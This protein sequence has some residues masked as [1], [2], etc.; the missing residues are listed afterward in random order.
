M[1]GSVARSTERVVEVL[2]GFFI[3]DQV[4]KRDGFLQSRDPRVTVLAIAGFALAVVIARSFLVLVGLALLTGFIAWRSAVPFKAL[5]A[6]SA[7]VPLFSAMIVLPQAVLLAGDPIAGV[8]GVTVTNTG[9][10][11]V[12][13]FTLR[14]GLGVA[15]LALLVTTTRVS[16]I[17][18]AL[19]ALHVPATVVWVMAITYRYLFLFF[20]ELRRL[21]YARN[22]R[23]NP[24]TSLR[25]GWTDGRRLAGTFLLRTLDRGVR[26]GRGMRA[27][28]GARA[29]TPYAKTESLDR[30]DYGLIIVAAVAIVGS[31]VVR[32][33]G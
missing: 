4:A 10:L 8:G 30:Y 11:Y 2:R 25:A 24:T 27:R 22:S 19:R 23:A 13:Q 17:L 28:G 1:T 29:P 33:L 9:V 32:W 20:E 7:I 21:L 18:A 15:L 14:V 5:I 3:T 26:V 6:R 16:A 31:G 12:I